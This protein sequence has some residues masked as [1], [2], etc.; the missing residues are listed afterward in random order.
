VAHTVASAYAGNRPSWQRLIQ[1]LPKL[2]KRLLGTYMWVSLLILG[3]SGLMFVLMSAVISGVSILGLPAIWV[4]GAALCGAI[5]FS[6]VF[7][8]AMIVCNL[9]TVVCVMEPDCCYGLDAIFKAMF[10]IRGRTQIALLMVLI[11]NMSLTLVENLFQYRVMGM[12]H[13]SR[14]YYKNSSRI[15]SSAF[16]EALLLIFMYSMVGV[17]EVVTSCVFYYTCKSSRLELGI[18]SCLNHSSFLNPVKY[19]FSCEKKIKLSECVV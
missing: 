1:Q 5:L 9:A 18:N 4:I 15:S 2:W 10:L 13:G 7:A 6:I 11:T 8:H 3:F 17:M 19:E 14:F 16:W 12:S